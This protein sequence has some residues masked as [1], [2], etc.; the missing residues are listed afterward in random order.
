MTSAL[1][2]VS[3]DSVPKL[4]LKQRCVISKMI[5]NNFKSNF[6][7]QEIGPFNEDT[8]VAQNLKQ[9]IRIAFGKTQWS[10]MT[11]SGELVG[12]NGTLSFGSDITF[13]I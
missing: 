10:V 8:L 12:K 9:A 13:T 7:K 2:R 5:L 11:L 3:I 4:K 1:P 6:G